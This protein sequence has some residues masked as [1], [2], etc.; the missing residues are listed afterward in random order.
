MYCH[1]SLL[2]SLWPPSL[3]TASNLAILYHELR[4]SL[5]EAHKPAQY[6][7]SWNSIKHALFAHQGKRPFPSTRMHVLQVGMV[8]FVLRAVFEEPILCLAL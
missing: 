2:L 7:V 5:G 6:N 3:K 1:S 8:T 4:V